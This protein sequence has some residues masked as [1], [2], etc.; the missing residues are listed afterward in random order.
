MPIRKVKFEV[1]S[2]FVALVKNLCLGIIKIK[3]FYMNEVEW[4]N[5]KYS[6]KSMIY[7]ILLKLGYIAWKCDPN[8]FCI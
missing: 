4:L 8:I 7:R 6:I 2:C 5:Y 1:L 3:E